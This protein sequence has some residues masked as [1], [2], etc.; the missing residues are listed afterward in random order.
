MDLEPGRDRRPD[1]SPKPG[2][3]NR[4]RSADHVPTPTAVLRIGDDA[5]RLA[6]PVAAAAHQLASTSDLVRLVPPEHLREAFDTGAVTFM[7]SGEQAILVHS[8]T[9]KIAGHADVQHP[10]QS[11]AQAAL[12]FQV[13]AAATQQYYLHEISGQ[14]EK[15]DLRLQSLER[16]EQANDEGGLIAI[17]QRLHNLRDRRERGL[18]SEAELI[19]LEDWLRFALDRFRSLERTLRH[20]I[21]ELNQHGADRRR[22]YIKHKLDHLGGAPAG[23]FENLLLAGR[24]LLAVQQERLARATSSADLDQLLEDNARLTTQVL[25]G[26]RASASPFAAVLEAARQHDDAPYLAE[27]VRDRATALS[28]R[29]VPSPKARDVARRLSAPL[30]HR[31]PAKAADLSI[32]RVLQA[33][34]ERRDRRIAL[35]FERTA[36][37]QRV[38]EVDL[39]TPAAELIARRTAGG[40]VELALQAPTQ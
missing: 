10:T 36:A 37:A 24:V 38:A 33:D 1:E 23:D 5:V 28:V 3:L 16:R 6:T 17:D 25:G 15:I 13:L 9:K 12:A 22:S 7:K 2:E 40:E 11:A 4:P 34:E 8:D 35:F 32:G 18:V 39:G 26:L 21:G 30:H 19:L 31:L 20:H 27:K 29:A 14:L